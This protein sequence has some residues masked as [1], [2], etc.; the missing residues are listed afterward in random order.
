VKTGIQETEEGNWILACAGMTDKRMK[1]GKVDFKSTCYL[2]P[3]ALKAR[4]V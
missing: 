3:L 1:M 2:K 4:V